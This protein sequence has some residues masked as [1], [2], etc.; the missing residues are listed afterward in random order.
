MMSTQASG[1]IRAATAPSGGRPSV[2]RD[3]TQVSRP[4]A[5]AG[6][7]RSEIS[8]HARQSGSAHRQKRDGQLATVAVSMST[9][10]FGAPSSGLWPAVMPPLAILSMTFRPGSLTSPN[11]V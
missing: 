1:T 4:P 8:V 2:R 7:G 6:T 9:G 10:S 3:Q 5:A 11:T